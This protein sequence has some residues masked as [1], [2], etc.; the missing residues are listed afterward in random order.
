MM[1][2]WTDF[3][4]AGD[5]N[6]PGLPAWSPYRGRVL[7]LVPDRIAPVDAAAEHH[8]GFWSTVD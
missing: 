7:S 6:G 8:C 5:P 4:R 1:R 3:A 2:Y